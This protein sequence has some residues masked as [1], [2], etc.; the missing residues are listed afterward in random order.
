MFDDMDPETMFTSLSGN[1]AEDML[2]FATMQMSAK[3]GIEKF[4][5]EGRK[6]TMLEL[7]QLLHCKVMQGHD[8]KT[9]TKQQKKV[10][11]KYLM[12]LK[13]KCCGRIKGCSC[14]DGQKQ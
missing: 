1:D 4:G 11:L 10:A 8:A 5:E 12:F 7:E 2:S 9:L 3:A 13:E 6:V 14:A